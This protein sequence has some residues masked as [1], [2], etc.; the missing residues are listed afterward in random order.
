LLR[1]AYNLKAD[2]ALPEDVAAEVVAEAE[3]GT[4]AQVTSEMPEPQGTR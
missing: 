2:A 1:A 4:D 3:L